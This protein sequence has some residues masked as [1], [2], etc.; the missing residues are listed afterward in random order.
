MPV[1]RHDHRT[2][3]SLDSVLAWHGRPGAFT[4]L[5]PEF[6]GTPVAE[7]SRGLEVGSESRLA[8]GPVLLPAALRLPWTARHSAFSPPSGPAAGREASFTDVQVS[9]P[10]A[11]WSHTHVFRDV[12]GESSATAIE[13]TVEYRLPAG[14]DRRAGLGRPARGFMERQLAETFLARSQRVD[15]DLA[16]HARFPAP[17]TVLVAGAGGLVGRQLVAFLRSGGHRVITLTRGR[18]SAPDTVAWN[19]ARGELSPDVFEGVDAVIHLGGEPIAG[20]FT[21]EHRER[22]LAS[23][24]ESTRTLVSAMAQ[25]AA[26]GQDVPRAFVCASASGFY[27]HDAGRVS[28]ESPAGEDFLAEVCRRWEAEVEKAQAITGPAGPVRTV[29]VRTGL[30]LSAAGGVLAAQL[31]LY[32]AGLGGPLGRG[33]MVQSWI[34]LDDMVRLYAFAALDGSLSGPVNA[35]A[36]H[37]VTQREFARTLGRVL[38]RPAILPTPSVAPRLLLGAQGAEELALSNLDLDVSLL[39]E[40]GFV[41]TQPDLEPALRRIL[42]R[43]LS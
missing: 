16:F 32:A 10:M 2:P 37:P 8:V 18:V 34:S 9:G 27:G 23:R 43:Q 14:L 1:F 5:V 31:P 7:P 15:E 3:H 6:L 38:R 30:I 11:S 19:P 12:P 22:V 20:R 24:V 13:D 33:E 21:P 28:E 41:H 36:P 35:A 25:R 29:M 4:R 40:S 26:A 39:L 42:G 17:R